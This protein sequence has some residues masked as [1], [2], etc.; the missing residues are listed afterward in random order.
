M[1][2]S[3]LSMPA[4]SRREH[5][6][7]F[8]GF[9]FPF[10]SV[11]SEVDTTGI[12]R[13]SRERGVPFS[14]LALFSLQDAVQGCEPMRY[15]IRGDAVWVH[16]LVGIST[17]VLREDRTFGFARIPFEPSFR[18]FR[19]RAE[20]RIAAAKRERGLPPEDPSADDVIY[21]SVLPWMRFSAFSNALP[22][23]EDSIPRIVFGKRVPQ[24]DRSVMPV[25]VEVHHAL[26]DGVHVAQFFE[27]LEARLAR[28]DTDLD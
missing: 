12:A 6:A 1:A 17:T 26:M 18:E 27:S 5:F 7:L 2:G 8:R 15:R 3:F 14:L 19:T 16:D 11:T 10:F 4:W 28:P 24:G 23:R 25:S 20:S 13:L 21:H 22:S 9:E